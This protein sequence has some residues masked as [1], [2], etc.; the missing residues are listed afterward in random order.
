MLD[1][2]APQRTEPEAPRFL[3]TWTIYDHPKDFPDHF[4]ARKW[5]VNAAGPTPTQDII[6]SSRL[7]PIREQLDGLGLV[8]IGRAASDDAT[9]VETWV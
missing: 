2:T 5:I 8:C 4:V 1:D 3:D 9:I 7:D 6:V